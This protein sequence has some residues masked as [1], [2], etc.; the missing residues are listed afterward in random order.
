MRL[1]QVPLPGN[2]RMK[3][4]TQQLQLQQLDKQAI[5]FF[6]AKAKGKGNDAFQSLRS[7]YQEYF[8]FRRKADA[9]L[10]WMNKMLQE[11]SPIYSGQ[12][13]PV[14]QINKMIA[15]LKGSDE[16]VLKKKM[17]D[18][19]ALNIYDEDPVGKMKIEKF[20]KSNYEY[21]SGNSFFESE[22]AELNELCNESWATVNNFLFRKFKF[23]LETQLTLV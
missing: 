13:I 8:E 22:L 15:D 3:R 2:W 16:P 20:I 4:S 6:L 7:A 1:K 17:Q 9:Y 14:E 5:S 18:W 21:F 23:I 11:I 19:L 10:E 12:T